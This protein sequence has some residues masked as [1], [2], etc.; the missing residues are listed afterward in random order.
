MGE[1]LLNPPAVASATSL[2]RVK[3]LLDTSSKALAFR[4]PPIPPTEAHFPLKPL[5]TLGFFRKV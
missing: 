5:K 1:A 4:A 2:G 3:F